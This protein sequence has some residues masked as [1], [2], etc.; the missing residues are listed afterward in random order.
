[1]LSSR[2]CEF[3]TSWTTYSLGFDGPTDERH[4]LPRGTARRHRPVSAITVA[5]RRF[6]LPT[7]P[8]PEIL[9]IPCHLSAVDG[10]LLVGSTRVRESATGD[11]FSFL[12][13][14]DIFV[15]SRI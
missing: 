3:F 6:T 13:L 9:N 15:F 5:C 2:D 10:N 7:C 1:M 11:S 8:G 12:C 4:P 14:F